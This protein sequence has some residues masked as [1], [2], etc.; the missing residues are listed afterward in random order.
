MELILW[1]ICGLVVA[2]GALT[3]VRGSGGVSAVSDALRDHSVR[4]QTTN[5]R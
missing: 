5:E 2:G 1:I 3:A 4:R